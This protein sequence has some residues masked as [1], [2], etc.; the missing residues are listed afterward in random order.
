MSLSIT[1]AA[2]TCSGCWRLKAHLVAAGT[3]AI[4]L[5]ECHHA[6]TS[7][8]IDLAHAALFRRRWNAV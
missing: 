6:Q 1:S 3:G 8:P 7:E 4:D 5:L 2:T